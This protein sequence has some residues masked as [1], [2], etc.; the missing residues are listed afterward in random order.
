[1]KLILHKGLFVRAEDGDDSTAS[2]DSFVVRDVG[3]VTSESAFTFE[4]GVRP[5][6]EAK[7]LGVDLDLPALPFQLQIRYTKL[8]GMKCIRIISR[9]QKATRDRDQAEEAA[10]VDVLGLNA[11]QKSAKIAQKGEYTYGTISPVL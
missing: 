1:M 2:R 8:D 5:A 7:A 6:E 3:N 11:V 10:N 9:E 4:F